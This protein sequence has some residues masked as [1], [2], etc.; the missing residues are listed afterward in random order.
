M[1]VYEKARE[2][3]EAILASEESAR[4]ADA[5][6]GGVS[7]A[8]L[9]KASEDYCALINEALDIVRMSVGLGSACGGCGRNCQEE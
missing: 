9:N 2:L 6:Q 8:E 5:K 7:E 1:I 3:A 4:L